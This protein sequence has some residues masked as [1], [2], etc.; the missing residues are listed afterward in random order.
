MKLYCLFEEHWSP[1]V[2]E[3]QGALDQKK[4]K[5]ELETMLSDLKEELESTRA[6]VE[7]LEK[8]Y[9][10]DY[11]VSDAL[12]DIRKL[13]ANIQV[14][15]SQDRPTEKYEQS[16]AN[17][18]QQMEMIN[19]MH[20]KGQELERLEN[21]YREATILD[22]KD[23]ENPNRPAS[24]ASQLKT[25]NDWLKENPVDI[26]QLMEAGLSIDQ[27]AKK[28]WVKP[29]SVKSWMVNNGDLVKAANYKGIDYGILIPSGAM[30]APTPYYM[31]NVP[32]KPKKTEADFAAQRAKERRQEM[33][34]YKPAGEKKSLDISRST[35]DMMAGKEEKPR[36]VTGIIPP[37]K[38]R[39]GE[40][41]TP[42][43]AKEE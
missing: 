25:I 32:A 33:Y 34:D 38:I 14:A 11:D 42:L 24:V 18:L 41:K 40:T 19:L 15:K 6:E 29:S 17:R 28:L 22:L 30:K 20:I 27:I 5:A 12:D 3:I 4:R 16:L 2:Y 8:L 37:R 36:I 1:E 13:K 23:P 10:Q 31:G 43:G 9:G 39:T 35:E 26:F 21:K 7:E